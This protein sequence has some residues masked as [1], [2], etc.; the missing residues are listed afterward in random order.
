MEQMDRITTQNYHLGNKEQEK[1][2]RFLGQFH[3]VLTKLLTLLREGE[4][5][6]MGLWNRLGFVSWNK[7]LI[8]EKVEQ[9]K[10]IVQETSDLHT[11]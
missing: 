10:D 4:G 2:D 11:L 7:R 8:R 5:T 1:W 9:L 3:K 6:E